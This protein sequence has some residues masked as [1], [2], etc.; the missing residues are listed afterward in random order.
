MSHSLYIVY[1]RCSYK[2][3]KKTTYTFSEIIN[4]T[5]DNTTGRKEFWVKKKKKNPG[6]LHKKQ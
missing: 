4:Y 3:N 6:K 5:N 1:F 2:L